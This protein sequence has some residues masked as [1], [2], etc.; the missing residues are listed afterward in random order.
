MRV[1]NSM[2]YEDKHF[3]KIK[4]SFFKFYKYL[5]NFII[6]NKEKSS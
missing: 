4:K 6:L 2:I 1:E 3:F 5:D